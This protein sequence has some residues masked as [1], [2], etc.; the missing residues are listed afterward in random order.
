MML[1]LGPFAPSAMPE[2]WREMQRRYQAVGVRADDPW[3]EEL[4]KHAKISAYDPLAG[5]LTLLNTSSSAERA[6]HANWRER[7]EAYFTEL[8]PR[9]D[10]RLLVHN[11]ADPL[12]NVIAWFHRHRHG[13]ARA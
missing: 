10:D 5:R 8:F 4:P 1:W 9:L 3:D 11:T 7:R 6:A 2:Q 13:G 12:Q